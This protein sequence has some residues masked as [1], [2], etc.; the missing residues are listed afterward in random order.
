MAGMQPMSELLMAQIAWLNEKTDV[1][2]D[3]EEQGGTGKIRD[4]FNALEAAE[5]K[6]GRKKKKN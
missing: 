2:D 4:E 3:A 1:D 6:R 5:K